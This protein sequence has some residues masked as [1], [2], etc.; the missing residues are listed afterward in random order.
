[1]E[2]LQCRKV[3]EKT[4]KKFCS[5]SCSTRHRNLRKA[6]PPISC[7]Q[8]GIATRNPR[9][10]SVKCAGQCN[11]IPR[12][13]YCK[14]CQQP[15]SDRWTGR[16]YCDVC[17]Y[18]KNPNFKNW[19]TITFEDLRATRS[20]FQAHAHIRGLARRAYL[21]SKKPRYC[22]LCGYRHHYEVCHIKPISE[23]S[24]TETVGKINSVDNLIAL[25]PNCHWEV[26]HGIAHIA[27][28]GDDPSRKGYE[29]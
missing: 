19:D 6:K 14:G 2:C 25:C 29:P 27:D 9:F 12:I 21:R 11:N 13:A 26:D 23:F 20:T 15:I 5:L 18:T 16:K 24:D 7:V 8:C 1:M 22:V 10:C 4:Q 17:R 3:L 28:L